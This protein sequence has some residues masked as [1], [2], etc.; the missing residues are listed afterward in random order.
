MDV[1]VDEGMDV[2]DLDAIPDLD[3]YIGEWVI[4]RGNQVLAHDPDGGV[5]LSIAEELGLEDIVIWMVPLPGYSVY[6]AT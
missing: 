2:I 5:I 6:C 4:L 3:K 1:K